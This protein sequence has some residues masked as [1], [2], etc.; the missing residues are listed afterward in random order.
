MSS[1]LVDVR[2]SLIALASSV[3][4][5]P[6]TA[7]ALPATQLESAAWQPRDL[8]YRGAI[9]LDVNASDVERG[10]FR[11]SETITVTRSG[12]LTL[13][14]PKWVPGNHAPTAQIE[15][16]S[17]LVIRADG[18]RL[19]WVRDPVD[20]HAF[21]VNVPDGVAALDVRF[22][23]LSAISSADG[24]VVMTPEMLNL[25]WFSLVLYPA[26][27]HARQIVVDAKVRVPD[28]WQLT[29]QLDVSSRD[30]ATV[31]FNRVSLETLIDSPIF[32]GRHFRRFELGGFDEAP[33]FLDVVADEPRYLE[34]RPE[35]I[36]AHRRLVAEASKLFGPPPFRR[37]TFMLGLTRE[38]GSI[39]T[40]HLASSENT[41][42]LEYLSDWQ[43]SALLPHEL[44][45]AWN[46]KA[47]RPRDLWSPDF[48]APMRNSMLWLYEGQTQFWGFVL[49]ARSSLMTGDQVMDAF[50]RLAAYHTIQP[51][52]RWRPLGDT[53][54][55]AIMT[56]YL[57][58][59]P[60][61]SWH[62]ALNDS[63]TEADLMWLEA[64][65]FIREL[66]GEQRSLDDFA[67]AFFAGGGERASLYD[68]GDVVAALDRV[69]RYDWAAF[70]AARI[71]S[72]A[73]SAPTDWLRRS[74]Y[75]LIFTD[76]PTEA[77]ASHERRAD[78]VDLTHSLGLVLRGGTSG[79]VSQVIW[80][81][82][83][84]AAGIV[85]GATIRSVND[86]AYGPEKLLTAIS[87]NRGG[88]RPIRLGVIDRGRER[89]VMI[90]YRGGLRFPRL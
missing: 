75:R 30:G 23:F 38:L 76:T 12:R 13:L 52:R 28:G 41:R 2:R 20:M 72:T 83:A 47:R 60:S 3:M 4:L 37:Y 70:L 56:R 88:G 85:V 31:R 61:P 63:Y 46:G 66:S 25:Q 1:L 16:L 71:D 65:G 82:P 21:H 78:R 62:R 26:G 7:P 50:A 19:R 84:F 42:P 54:N 57:V 79:E 32:A 44:T 89:V 48:N 39:G 80:N 14:F 29:T 43:W 49:A 58:E 10:I 15:R 55:D 69:Q 40:E 86:S 68:L 53:G 73:P 5:V 90:D 74:G 35:A 87:D 36:D 17:G 51:G 77:F 64:D 9:T 45:H 6:L 24:R 67:R 34:A 8:P 18:R 81:S 59:E 27:H 11:V 22:E 33:A